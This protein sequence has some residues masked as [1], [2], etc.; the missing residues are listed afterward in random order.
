MGAAAGTAAGLGLQYF[1][2][3]QDV[4]VK[5]RCNS[6]GDSDKICAPE[7]EHACEKCPRNE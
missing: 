1:T 4:G 7:D 3:I 6:F 2:K 5:R